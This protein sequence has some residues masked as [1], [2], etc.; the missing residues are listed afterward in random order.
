ML[1]RYSRLNS[2][3]INVFELSCKDKE[4]TKIEDRLYQAN[5]YHR[6]NVEVYY[7]NESNTLRV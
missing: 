3:I 6:E 2:E 4:F 5:E 7:P 1:Y